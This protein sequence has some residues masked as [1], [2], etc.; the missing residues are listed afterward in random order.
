MNMHASTMNSADAVEKPKKAPP[1]PRNGVDVPQLFAAI[2]LVRDN[3]E[4]AAFQFRTTTEWQSGTHSRSTFSGFHGCGAEMAHKATFTADSDHLEVLCGTDHGP[5]PVEYL[6][7]AI[8]ACLTAGIGNIASARG[9]DLHSVSATVEG[10]IDL[11]GILGITDEVRN[12]YQGIRVAFTVK[13]DAPEE[14]LREIVSQSVARSA[15]FDVLTKGV[16][17]EVT[18]AN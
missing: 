14:K 9:V 3:P 18:V 6:L 1:V 11:R 13:G 5:T 17:V 2:G 4:L 16:P 8:A 10:D 12:G 15:V 7:H